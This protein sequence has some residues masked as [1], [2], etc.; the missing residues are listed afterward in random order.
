MIWLALLVIPGFIYF[1]LNSNSDI[2]RDEREGWPFILLVLVASGVFFLLARASELILAQVLLIPSLAS[3]AGLLSS[4]WDYFIPD[5]MSDDP[6]HFSFTLI[7]AS[8]IAVAFAKRISCNIFQL[9]FRERSDRLLE[10]LEQFIE[11][12]AKGGKPKLVMIESEKVYIGS[13]VE[14]SLG[15]GEDPDS[16]YF[17]VVRPSF[18]AIRTEGGVLDINTFYS[19]NHPLTKKPP[20]TKPIDILICW[21][22]VK[23]VRE[24]DW[25]YM[26]ECRKNGTMTTDKIASAMDKIDS[27]PLNLE[28]NAT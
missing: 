19:P 3:L 21:K 1:R 20:E 9:L 26:R 18:S 28:S 17:L 5:F 27:L 24:F 6:D 22:T 4:F 11:D 7:F 2:L 12:D 14:V 16:K 25:D 15:S 13:L 10:F 8:I 23:T